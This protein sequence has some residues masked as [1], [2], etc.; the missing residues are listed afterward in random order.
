MLI[1]PER[2]SHPRYGCLLPRPRPRL[3]TF[4]S[5]HSRLLTR[6]QYRRIYSL[7][8]SRAR[9]QVHPRF[10]LMATLH[11]QQPPPQRAAL[12][13]TA[14]TQTSFQRTSF[15]CGNHRT[16]VSLAVS[17]LLLS[18]DHLI[19]S[20]PNCRQKPIPRSSPRRIHSRPR[21]GRCTRSRKRRFRTGSGWRTLPGE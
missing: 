18:L 19:S 5:L 21:C 14:S 17:L 20:P 15:R 10:L 11:V 3:P 7:T 13:Q 16:R 12:G 1:H 4:Q 6:W 8:R 2:E 9:L